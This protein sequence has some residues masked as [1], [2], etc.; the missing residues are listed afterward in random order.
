ML[1][2][3]L[4]LSSTS[5]FN[6]KTASSTTS[7]S[8]TLDGPSSDS[9]STLPGLPDDITDDTKPLNLDL[10]AEDAMKLN[11]A[12][13]DS[14]AT[15]VPARPFVVPATV[16]SQ[17]SRSTAINC[18]TSAIYYEAASEADRGQR[19]VA[20]VVLNRVRH[21]A[22]PNNICGVVFQGSE[23]STGCQFSFTCD[24][25]LAR[26]PIPAFWK[27]AQTI[28]EQALS[29]TVEKSVGTATHY[30]TV[31]IVPYWAKSLDKVKTVGS[32]IFYRWTGYWGKRQAFSQQYIGEDLSD[33]ASEEGEG[34]VMMEYQLDEQMSDERLSYVPEVDPIIAPKFEA[35]SNRARPSNESRIAADNIQ[36]PLAADNDKGTLILD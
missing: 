25:S 5:I 19:A 2:V 24:G 9:V 31:W 27:R 21:P 18:L 8:V 30:H 12:V 6:Q 22:Y 36:S 3:G 13:P 11:S 33:I 28:A 29:G 7:D 23:R 4:F 14:N 35:L 1:A 34:D 10:S 32:H 20:Q 16:A 15:L 26:K 17:L